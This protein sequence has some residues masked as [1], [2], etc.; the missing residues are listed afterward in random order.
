VALGRRR[1]FAEA[2]GVARR[3]FG[4]PAAGDLSATDFLDVFREAKV[5][6]DLLHDMETQGA[7]T[8]RI[9]QLT[10]EKGEAPIVSLSLVV[11]KDDAGVATHWEGMI[12]DVTTQK[13]MELQRDTLITELQTSLMFLNDPIKHALYR[14][15]TC[16]PE[17]PIG[18]AAEQMTRQGSSA[19][20]VSSASGAVIGIVT[21]RDF[22]ERVAARGL[23]HADPVFEIMSSPIISVPDSALVYEAILL[24]QEKGKRHLA[25]KDAT[26]QTTG[27]VSNVELLHFD[28]Y[29]SVVMTREIA[30]APAV[31]GIAEIHERLPRLVAA[32]VDSGA[33]PRN[34]TRVITATL[35]ATIAR[36][37]ALSVERIGP[38]PVAF[39]F[40]ALGSE[41]REEKTLVGDQDNAIIY[42]DVE[43]G[44][45]QQASTY[46]LRL[47]TEVCDGLAQ[48]GYP[49]CKGGI[50]AKAPRWC[51]PLSRWKGYFSQWI[52]AAS[53][54]DFLEINMFFDFRAVSGAEELLGEL[55]DHIDKR[56][57]LTVPFFVNYAQ[58]ALLYKPPLSFFGS[59]VVESVGGHPKTFDVKDAM[60]PIVGFARL[61]ALQHGVRDTHTLERLQRLLEKGAIK[62]TLYEEAV[63]AYNYL[64]QL[65]LKHQAM[66]AAGSGQPTNDVDLQALTQIETTMLK[67]TFHQVANIQKQ[68]QHDFVGSGANL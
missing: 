23:S 29:S 7:V 1:V 12:Q 16:G 3:L 14:P 38:P 54:Q 21:D 26:G 41:G 64:M 34:V 39:A 46:F 35:D 11:V 59:I 20:F 60:R 30:R 27:L 68:L 47:G 57:K 28:R 25:V 5:R 50:M 37:V 65:R 51:Q 6:A 2:N 13:R 36:L 61:Y 62:R 55:R 52:E 33:K 56:L 15:P 45:E 49:H 17:E 53:P 67:Q 9:V 4:L 43:A 66:N 19:L 58:N 42:A 31:K 24:M 32:L 40:I 18:R 10:H 22:R 8:A 48:I 44:L 63:G